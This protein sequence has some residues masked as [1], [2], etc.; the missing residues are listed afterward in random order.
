MGFGFSLLV[1]KLAAIVGVAFVYRFNDLILMHWVN[2]SC[3]PISYNA[4]FF[5][6]LFIALYEDYIRVKISKNVKFLTHL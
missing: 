4:A 2:V 3:I 1:D 6:N 5:K